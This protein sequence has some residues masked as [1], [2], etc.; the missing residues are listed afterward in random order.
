MN[1]KGVKNHEYQSKYDSS[2]KIFKLIMVLNTEEF[3]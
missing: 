1:L 3:N 2:F